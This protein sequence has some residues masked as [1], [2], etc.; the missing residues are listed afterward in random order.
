MVQRIV[1]PLLIGIGVLSVALAVIGIFLPLLPTTPF[2]LLAVVC[3][4]KSSDRLHQWL[5]NN[6]WFGRYIRDYREGRGV[7][8][9]AKVIA[10]IMLWGSIGYTVCYCV[11]LLA[12]RILLLVIALAVSVYLLRLKTRPAERLP[13]AGAARLRE[14]ANDV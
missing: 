11:P 3:F 9:R 12:A 8:A 6:R 5:L 4:S 14:K 2:L 1:R 10:L 13:P 7:P